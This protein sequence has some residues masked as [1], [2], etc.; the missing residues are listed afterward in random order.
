VATDTKGGAT[1]FMQWFGSRLQLTPPLHLLVPEAL[2][3]DDGEMELPPPT[4]SEVEAILRRT[5]LQ[6]K[7]DPV[8]RKKQKRVAVLEGF[9]LRADTAVHANDCEALERL[10]R[11]GSRGPIAECRLRKLDGGC[12]EYTAREGFPA[13]GSCVGETT[14]GAGASVASAPDELPRSP[15]A[16]RET[17]AAG[18]QSRGAGIEASTREEAKA[19]LRRAR[20]FVYSRSCVATRWPQLRVYWVIFLVLQFRIEEGE[21]VLKRENLF[22]LRLVGFVWIR[23]LVH[24]LTQIRTTRQGGNRQV[25][26]LMF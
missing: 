25:R 23:N 26:P 18:H 20:D 1:V 24:C 16:K 19:G 11:Y 12:I 6:V 7:R 3:N 13:D 9:S 10:C 22:P 17:A 2:W 14:A 5:L 15:R 8:S 4:D 21:A